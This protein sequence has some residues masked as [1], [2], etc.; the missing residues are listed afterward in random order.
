MKVA[1]WHVSTMG[2]HT[3]ARAAGPHALGTT[4]EAHGRGM[5]RRHSP[6][7]LTSCTPITPNPRPP[8]ASASRRLCKGAH[9]YPCH[10]LGAGRAVPLSCRSTRR[11][12]GAGGCAL[13]GPR[14]DRRVHH[15]VQAQART[16]PHLRRPATEPG[17]CQSWRPGPDML[18]G[19][20]Q[21][22][23]RGVAARGRR[24]CPGAR[25]ARRARYAP[26]P[27]SVHALACVVHPGRR[28][29]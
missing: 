29:S 2:R 21:R 7:S 28:T 6:H 15:V 11:L 18:P 27:T 16:A 8:C 14:A 23:P 3:D 19:R 25:A 10:L 20:L 5:S 26:M 12:Q 24:P 1:A 13:P 17:E 22:R 4:A 9:V